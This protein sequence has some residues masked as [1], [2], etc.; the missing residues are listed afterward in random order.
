MDFVNERELL[1]EEANN[2][3]V[4]ENGQNKYQQNYGK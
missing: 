3:P 1:M 2:C 4:Y